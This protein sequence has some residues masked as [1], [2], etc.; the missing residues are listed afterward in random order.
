MAGLR[1]WYDWQPDPGHHEITA[2]PLH[3]G[4]TNAGLLK[5]KNAAAVMYFLDSCKRFEAM[6]VD[7]VRA[8]TLE[9][10]ML[11]RSG[12]D[13]ASPE[14]KYQ[15]SSLTDR[16]FSGLHLMCLMFAGFKCFAPEYDLAMDLHNSF[17]TALELYQQQGGKG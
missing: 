8:V 9:I 12:L 6:P 17:L 5:A 15:L 4:T 2:E 16:K 3:E 14:E 11:G 7:Q 13:C 10:A 1:G